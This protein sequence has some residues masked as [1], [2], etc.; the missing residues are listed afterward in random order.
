MW[1]EEF[2]LLTDYD[3]GEFRRLANYILS[4][5]FIVKE[6]FDISKN[7]MFLNNDYR[8]ME[9]LYP[10]MKAYFEII[11]WSLKKDAE[12]QVFSI[13]SQYDNNRMRMN[14]FSTLFL[15]ALRLIYEEE[16]EKLNNYLNVRTETIT[17]I[18]KMLTLGLIQKA[19]SIKDREEAQKLLSHFNIIQR[20]ESKW[21]TQG[22][23]LIVYPSIL[24]VIS[25]QGI[26]EMLEEIE[27]IS[28]RTNVDEEEKGV[29]DE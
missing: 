10:A 6:K 27:E 1:E 3:K 23:H 5:T 21:E 17:V 7:M 15:Y 8:L 9:R 18:E 28:N 11:G 14:S 26:N 25:I 29:D 19:P 24:S 16:R 22:N 2:N 20:I 4:H 13:Y 12:Y